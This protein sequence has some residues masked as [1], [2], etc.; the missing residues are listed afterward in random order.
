MN[1]PMALSRLSEILRGALDLAR[2]D[3]SAAL[4][5]LDRGLAGARLA[6]DLESVAR[7]AK[8]AGAVASSIGQN[9][10][11]LAYLQEAAQHEPHA[12]LV[13]LALAMVLRD[14]GR[15]AEAQSAFFVCAKLA[16]EHEP[17]TARLAMGAALAFGAKRPSP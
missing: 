15:D 10:R 14:L 4:D 1:R 2:E 7:M 17:E 16:A 11:A 3:P 13:Q 9:E 12:P 6:G 5:A 8:H